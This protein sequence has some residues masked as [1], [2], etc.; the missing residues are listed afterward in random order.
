[1]KNLDVVVPVKNEERNIRDL[2]E[3][4]ASSISKKDIDFNIIVVVDPSTDNTFKVLRELSAT[5]PI[6][7]H[8]K[9]GKP[10]KGYSLIEGFRISS[11]EYLAFVDGD[12]Q[13]PP[14]MIPEMLDELIKGNHGVVIANRKSYPG[15]AHRGIGSSF[16][17]VIIG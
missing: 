7:I 8:K 14:E 2:I 16:N 12:L 9:I 6:T 15:A 11:A 3:R 5:Y 13:Y 17:K 10:G 4:L 1:M